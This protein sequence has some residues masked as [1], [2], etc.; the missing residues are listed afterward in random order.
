VS[1]GVVIPAY[2]P[3]IEVLSAY[4]EAI[5]EEIDPDRIRIELDSP[6]GTTRE[7][8][9][10]LPV[11]VNAV[12]ARRGKG[13]AITAG[14][15]ALETDVLAFADADGATPARELRR[16]IDPVRDG[17][18]DLATGS[19][20]HPD[21]EV[22]DSQSFAREHLGDGFAWLARQL[23]DVSLYDYQC[24]AKAVTAEG[25]RA[26]RP[27]I[28]SPGFAWDIELIAM[29]GATGLS[30]REVPIEWHDKPDSTVPPVR[31]S[32]QLAKA[33]VRARHRAKRLENSSLHEAIDSLYD[34]ST[35]LIERE[36]ATKDD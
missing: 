28:S 11:T 19:R 24:G 8:L 35:P 32:I 34:D 2:R 16:V 18:V 31:T 5:R 27:Y 36:S 15:Q 9:E 33:L 17:E 29:A 12:D 13:T 14:F 23:L 6:A 3:D 20:R 30:I 7:R 1:V 22:A 25:W 10:A 21:A 26:V 4:V